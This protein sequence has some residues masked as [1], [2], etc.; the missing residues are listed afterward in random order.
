M[1]A[2]VHA[3]I[4]DGVGVL[5]LRDVENRNVLSQDLVDAAQAAHQDFINQ[6]VRVAVL[7]AEGDTY[8][9]GRDANAVRVPGVPP[10][11]AVF[12]DELEASPIAWVGAI[13]GAVRGPA[14][15]MIST[16]LH[17]VAGAKASF[18]VEEL[19]N[20]IYPRPVSQEMA[21]I[22]GPRKIANLMITGRVLDAETAVNWGLVSEATAE[23]VNAVALQRARELNA[24]DD[25]LLSTLREN[26]RVRFGT[27]PEKAGS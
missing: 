4:V 20:G 27:A 7:A 3:E 12:I 24:L 6:G 2:L 14:T 11:G 15:H 10:A 19:L 21:R 13:D 16:L 25:T 23:D 9:G 18:A 8:C 26:W 17:T 5:T 1:N 22:L